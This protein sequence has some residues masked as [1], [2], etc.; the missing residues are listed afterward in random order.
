MV[1]LFLFGFFMYHLLCAVFSRSPRRSKE[2]RDSKEKRNSRDREGSRERRKSG[3]NRSTHER[4]S[5]RGRNSAVKDEP[6]EQNGDSH[7]CK[8]LALV[9]VV[10]G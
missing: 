10:V 4:D 9:D 8:K 3:D 1:Q 5:D 6:M 7:R 2:R